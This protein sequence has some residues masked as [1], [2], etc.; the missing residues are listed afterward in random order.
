MNEMIQSE[1]SISVVAIMPDNIGDY[2]NFVLI[3]V[4]ANT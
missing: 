2:E 4:K 1:L 3:M